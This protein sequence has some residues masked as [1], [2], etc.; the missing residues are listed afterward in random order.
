MNLFSASSDVGV[1]LFFHCQPG[2]L[3][4]VGRRLYVDTPEFLHAIE[5][6]DFFEEVVPIIALALATLVSHST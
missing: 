2:G 4:A 3:N 5:S 6:H 1:M